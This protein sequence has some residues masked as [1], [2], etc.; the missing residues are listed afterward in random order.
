MTIFK[1]LRQLH[2]GRTL[3]SGEQVAVGTLA[4]NRQGIFFAYQDDYL[5]RFGNLS[6]FALR[7]DTA[8]QLAPSEPYDGL[9]GVFA[10]SLPDGWGL[11]LQDR[12]FRR[13]GILPQQLT[14][15]DRLAFVGHRGIGGLFFEPDQSVDAEDVADM[16]A[17]GLAAQAVFDRQSEDVLQSLL[18]AGS[19]GGARPKAQVFMPASGAALV[20]SAPQPGDEAWIVKFTSPHLPLG[21]E[22]GL[23]EA[24]YL[25]MVAEAQ[26]NPCTWRLLEAPPASGAA[27][28]LAVRRFDWHG[29]NGRLH[30]HSL[31]GLLNADFR[32]PSLDY[33]DLIKASR[34]LCQSV[35]VGEIQFR[36]AVF[37]LFACN[38][39]DHG[40]NW[41]FLQNDAGEWQVSP[42]Y[43]ATFSPQRFGEHATAFAGFGKTPSVSAMQKLARHAGLDWPDAQRILRHT[44]DVL[45]GFA[46]HARH[47]GITPG[48]LRL[49]QAALN[50]VWQ[51]N[52][53]L[54]A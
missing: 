9:H 50:Q 47:V 26:L 40:K 8:L 3:A 49:I 53:H 41:A 51:A 28:W 17:L 5:A 20:R 23:C 33:E 46:A 30:Q 31:A 15:L 4:Q 7:A 36:R 52:R 6:P 22:E 16:A 18:A 21:H 27:Q 29:E 14:P 54:T 12:F 11:L 2:V 42:F 32:L 48:T 10:D 13:Q 44:L 1:P 24:V 38:Q 19:S 35:A 34:Q 25:T 37:N 43:D 39:D 45:G